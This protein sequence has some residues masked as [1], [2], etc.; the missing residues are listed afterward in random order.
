MAV[1]DRPLFRRILEFDDLLRRR[2]AV[3][4]TSLAARWKT[5][6][7]T[8]QRFVAFMRDEMDAPVVFDRKRGSFRYSDPAWHLPWIPVEGPG[9]FA[10]GVASKVLQLYEGTPVAEGLREAFERLSDVMP[11]E[12]RV[13][14]G[15]FVERLYIHPQPIRLVDPAVW[16]AVATAI[17]E[18][19]VLK[20][21]YQKPT[22]ETSVRRLAPYGL[23]LAAGDWLVAA[24][25]RDDDPGTVK[26]FYVARIRE[27]EVG[28]EV[29]AVPRDFDLKRH[30]GETIGIFVGS[31]PFRFRVRFTKVMAAWVAEVRW[32]PNQRLT[33][34]PDGGLELEL[35][36]GSL[37]EA[38]RFV[39][40]FGGDAVA[41]SPAPLV[42]ALRGETEAMARAYRLPISETTT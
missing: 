30:F 7:K 10:I 2:R 12:I 14:P 9:L 39:L 40:S 29:F 25:D 33:T 28:S 4:A 34:L 41:V 24:Q 36:A 3:N 37:F 15:A 18:K 6:T 13:S 11:P 19:T 1:K 42:E 8:V 17:R 38:R 23:V 27:A 16:S 26:T 5:S 20:V 35:P 32:H 31:S 22:G 21:R